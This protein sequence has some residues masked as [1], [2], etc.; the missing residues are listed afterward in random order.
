MRTII[1]AA[2]LLLLASLATAQVNIPPAFKVIA[3][4]DKDKGHIIYADNIIRM[5]PVQKQVMKIV[6]GQNVVEVVTEY[7]SVVETR[8]VLIEAAKSRVITPDGKQLALDE[9]W[10]RLKANDVFAL[11]ADSNTPAKVYL[12]A[13]SPDTLVVIPPAVAMPPVPVPVPK[14]DRPPELKKS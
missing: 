9:V 6:N 12:R 2:A 8:N 10:K 11:A 4:V 5:V 1:A 13:L 3:N 7:V 14:L